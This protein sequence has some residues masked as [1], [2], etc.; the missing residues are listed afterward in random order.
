MKPPHHKVKVPRAQ[1]TYG[2][3]P[4]RTRSSWVEEGRNSLGKN[5]RKTRRKRGEQSSPHKLITPRHEYLVFHTSTFRNSLKTK[6][7][8]WE[9]E[10]RS[11]QSCRSSTDKDCMYELWTLNNYRQSNNIICNCWYELLFKEEPSLVQGK[12]KELVE[13]RSWKMKDRDNFLIQKLT[14]LNFLYM[15]FVIYPIKFA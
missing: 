14:I 15:P 13:N 7:T 10:P 12:L 1:L 6:A 3:I 11:Y 5:E 2:E 8:L 9:I 4:H